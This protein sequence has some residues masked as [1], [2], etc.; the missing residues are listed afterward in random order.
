MKFAPVSGFGITLERLVPADLELVRKWRNDP[1]VADFMIFRDYISEDDQKRWHE[2]VENPRNHYSVIVY[3]GKKVG[4]SHIKNIDE[5]RNTGEGGM[6]IYPEEL[7]NSIVSWRAAV[8]GSDWCFRDWG[9]EEITGRV[10]KANRRAIRF[11]LG[12]GH[13]FDPADPNLD[14]LTCRLTKKAY[15]ERRAALIEAIQ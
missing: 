8:V 9:L 4:L 1:K 14:Y 5:V 2:K 3:E 15:E 7:R 10:L 13:V 11:N 12:L 6:F